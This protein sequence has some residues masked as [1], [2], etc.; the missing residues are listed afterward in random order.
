MILQK[1]S[2]VAVRLIIAIWALAGVGTASLSLIGIE[3]AGFPDGYISPYDRLTLLPQTVLSVILLLTGIFL[4]IRSA[5]NR[6]SRFDVLLGMAMLLCLYLPMTILEGC[7]R[8]QMCTSIFES[9]TGMMVDDGAG[10]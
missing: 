3:S 4:L 10:G 2:E 9:T 7:P 1:S 6:T 8:W 5:I